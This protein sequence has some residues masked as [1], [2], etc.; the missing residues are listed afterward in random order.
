M[1]AFSFGLS[2][3]YDLTRKAPF[4]ITFAM[5]A[6][7]LD[8]IVSMSVYQVN[9][10]IAGL[11]L[12]GLAEFRDGRFFSAGAILMLASN[13]KV[14]P[15]VFLVALALRF[16]RT[17]WIGAL[18]AGMVALLLPALFVG[19]SHNMEMH[20]AWFSVVLGDAGGGGILDILSAFQRI[21]WK[22]VGLPLRWLVLVTSIPTFIAYFCLAKRPDWRP[23]MA[24][25][26]ASLL[27]LSPRTEVFT[28]VLLAPS[29]V[30]MAS[31]CAESGQGIIRSWAGPLFTVLAVAIASC[32]YTDPEWYR[33]ESPREIVRVVG[34]M[35]FW[36][37]TA[38]ILGHGIY[39]SLK[40]GKAN[41][42]PAGQ[43]TKNRETESAEQEITHTTKPAPS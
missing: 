1:L 41:G 3:W 16:R 2:R 24:F 20:I 23:W 27:L 30:L 29:Y 31:W 43:G 9:A 28:Y 40:A 12:L 15:V 38:G 6:A 8:L 7:F 13:L 11:M 36:V 34:A 25:G 35:G 21:G 42:N 33:S 14:Y 17:Y 18:S 26:L 39:R 4:Y 22:S 10:L 32:R 37:L 19:W 5:L